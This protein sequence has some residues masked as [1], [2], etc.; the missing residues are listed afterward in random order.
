MSQD[1]S[2]QQITFRET[3]YSSR[4]S[5]AKQ[6]INVAPNTKGT[7]DKQKLLQKIREDIEAADNKKGELLSKR[8]QQN[9]SRKSS[10]GRQDSGEKRQTRSSVVAAKR[11]MSKED[12]MMLFGNAAQSQRSLIDKSEN[13]VN[14]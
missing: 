10:G 14:Q 1:E 3:R 5:S 6:S 4:L 11:T 2:S 13:V 8:K 9:N 7:Q 12:E